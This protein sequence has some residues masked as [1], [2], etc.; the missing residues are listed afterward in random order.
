MPVYEYKALDAGGKSISGIIDAESSPAARQKLRATRI[1]PVSISEAKKDAEKKE[2]RLSG[3]HVF[4]R[5]KPAEV[6][7][8]TRQ[9][10][11]LLTAG[12]P[13]VT[14]IDTLVP[15]SSSPAFRKILT[16]VKDSIVEGNSFS[17]ALSLFPAI[18]SPVYINMVSAGESSGTLEI[19]LDRLADIAEKREKLKNRIQS[20]LAYPILMSFVGAGVLIFLLT[21]IVPTISGIFEDMGQTLPTVTRVMIAVSSVLKSWWWVFVLL[22]IAGFFVFRYIRR[23]E[24]GGYAIDRIILRIP[25]IGEL[26]RKVAVARF[27]RTL[28]SLLENGVSLLQA[29]DIVR[30]IVGNRILS[31]AI[32]NASIE[33]GKGKGLSPALTET[34]VFPNLSLQMIQVG[35]QSGEL[36]N[37][38]TRIADV[39][40]TEVETTVANL[41]ALLEPVM[42]LVMGVVV[43]FI[44]LSICI[45]I[46]K[47]STL[48][49]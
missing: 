22:F 3:L 33:V 6:A 32:R 24:K 37:M 1:Y 28:G 14:A 40:E 46:F 36:E 13:L 2:S 10:A 43:G 17:G 26:V 45:P 27:S 4:S 42:I 29:M 38:L 23:T 20:A 19:V 7:L 41:A 39:Y 47:M 18:F 44:V 30:N 11:T 35:E 34:R 8:M 15:Q 48:M 49:R 5:V 16:Q 25:M 31:E 21:Y 9:L 12:F